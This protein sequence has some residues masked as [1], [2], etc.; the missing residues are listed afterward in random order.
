M[1]SYGDGNSTIRLLAQ[2]GISTDSAKSGSGQGYNV[3]KM[4]G[5]LEIDE[6]TLDKTLATN[7]EAVRDLFGKDS[8][9]DLVVDSGVAYRLD[10]IIKPFVETAGIISLKTD[11]LDKQISADKSKIATLDTQLADKEADLKD[12]YATMRTLERGWVSATTSRNLRRES[13]PWAE[14][15]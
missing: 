6:E 13:R 11:T 2:L 15:S 3:S 8:D 10:S 5:Y 4:R 7:F 9:G 14:A 1:N 12:K